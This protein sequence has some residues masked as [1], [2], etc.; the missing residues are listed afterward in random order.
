MFEKLKVGSLVCVSVTP[1]LLLVWIV[2]LGSLAKTGHF[3]LTHHLQGT[4]LVSFTALTS[5]PV[6]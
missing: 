2:E 1:K 3:Y 4:T 5:K 6:S